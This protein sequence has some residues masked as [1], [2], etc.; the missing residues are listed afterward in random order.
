MTTARGRSAR[1]DGRA[2]S[3][4]QQTVHKISGFY[5]LSCGCFQSFELLFD[6]FFVYLIE[7]CFSFAIFE[8]SLAK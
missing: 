5:Y 8:P 2:G 1:D 4:K 6:F 7:L 3:P